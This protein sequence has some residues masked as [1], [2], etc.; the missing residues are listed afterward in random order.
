MQS[1]VFRSAE[2]GGPSEVSEIADE[3]NQVSDHNEFGQEKVNS[4]G[5][6]F[7]GFEQLLKGKTFSR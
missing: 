3:L 7:S 1:L 4:D 5:T 2:R 6:D